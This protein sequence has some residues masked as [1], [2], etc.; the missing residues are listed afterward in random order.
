[1][2]NITTKGFY[3]NRQ[4]KKVIWLQKLTFLDHLKKTFWYGWYI[5][6]EVYD[7]GIFLCMDWMDE[8]LYCIIYPYH[9]SSGGRPGLNQIKN[10]VSLILPTAYT[11]IKKP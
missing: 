1:M 11:K 2:L 6:I 3:M 9:P 8:F 10:Y 4:G 7:V 5:R